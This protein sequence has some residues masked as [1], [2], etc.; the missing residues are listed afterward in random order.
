M[1]VY[2]IRIHL[3]FRNDILAF[4]NQGKIGEVTVKSPPLIQSTNTHTRIETL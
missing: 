4:Y 3:E 1:Y 2:S